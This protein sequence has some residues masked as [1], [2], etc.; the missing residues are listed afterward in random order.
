MQRTPNCS[1]VL[2]LA[3]MFLPFDY[4]AKPTNLL[5]RCNDGTQSHRFITLFHAIV[6]VALYSSY[7]AITMFIS[8]LGLWC[9][10]P[11][12]PILQLYRDGQFYW[13]RKSEYPKTQTCH[14]SQKLYHIML[15]RA[16]LA[17]AGFQL[18]MLVVIGTDCIANCKST[19]L[20]NANI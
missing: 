5:Y 14:K 6:K 1:I 7:K 8:L 2:T 17:W 10:M 4:C 3:I 11:L 20:L 15:Y 16:Y 9:I 12:S 13:W 19:G 18:A